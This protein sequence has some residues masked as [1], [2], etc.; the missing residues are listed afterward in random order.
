M[1]PF[2]SHEA[3]YQDMVALFEGDH[4]SHGYLFVGEEG[5][6]KKLVAKELAKLMLGNSPDLMILEGEPIKVQDIEAVQ[7]FL[8]ERPLYGDQKVVI[9]DDAHLMNVQSQNKLLKTLEEAP[10]FATLFFITHNPSK[11][12]DTILSRVITVHFKPLTT[13]QVYDLLEDAPEDLRILA[14]RFSQGSVRRARRILE[15]ER[16]QRIVKLPKVLFEQVIADDLGEVLK[17][18]KD[19]DGRDEHKELLDYMSYWLRDISL[20]REAP[21][22]DG[23]LYIMFKDALTEQGKFIRSDHLG[24]LERVIQEAREAIDSN[25]SLKV[26]M[27][28]LFLQLQGLLKE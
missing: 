23:A 10:S 1:L 28:R 18:L 13:G 4:L 15:D 6:G 3:Q 11:L 24:P 9:F 27:A 26:I 14:S 21:E 2:V 5:I 8:S 17:E 25:L 7:Q 20:L 22:S 16:L 19:L 12:L